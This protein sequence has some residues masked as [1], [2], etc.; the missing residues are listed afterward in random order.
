MVWYLKFN[1]EITSHFQMSLK[2]WPYVDKEETMF[3]HINGVSNVETDSS[4]KLH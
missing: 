2:K 1:Q 4:L 3:E